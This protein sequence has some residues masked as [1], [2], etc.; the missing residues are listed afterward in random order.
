M[1]PTIYLVFKGSC[2]EAMNHYAEVPGGEIGGVSRKSD[3]PDP[4]SPMP[5][6]GGMVMSMRRSPGNATVMASDN[7]EEI[8]RK[9]QRFR[10]SI[11]PESRGELD[12]VYA[13]LA[14]NAQSVAMAPE[15]TFSA[16]RFA[17][18]ADSYG[19]PRMLNFG[20]SKSQS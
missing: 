2:L 6:G 20:G 3:A 12:G 19:T 1:E 5:G 11:T 9:P 17:M 15:E 18:F 13:A 8:H 4:L 14:K 10:I 7:S 16:E